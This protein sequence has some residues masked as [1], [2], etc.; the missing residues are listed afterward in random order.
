MRTL[1]VARWREGDF[2]IELGPAPI[3]A[4]VAEMPGEQP[5][6]RANIE[7]RDPFMNL[8][9]EEQTDLF[10]AIISPVKGA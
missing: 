6:F 3:S 10:N 5:R 4:T 2:E 7:G 9:E 1:G 8:T